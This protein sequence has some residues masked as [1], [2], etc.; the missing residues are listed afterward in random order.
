MEPHS[1]LISS[2]ALVSMIIL[3]SIFRCPFFLIFVIISSLI[4]FKCWLF[5]FVF[6]WVSCFLTYFFVSQT[7][8]C[9]LIMIFWHWLT[10][11][12]VFVITTKISWFSTYTAKFGSRML[13]ILHFH[14]AVCQTIWTP[15]CIWLILLKYWSESHAVALK[16]WHILLQKWL[17][18]RRG[19]P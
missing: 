18:L 13:Q 1:S 3:L 17:S 12:S 10:F 6:F 15:E 14:I 9:S 11:I 2:S 7:I 8:S 19:W 4:L 16:F 5:L